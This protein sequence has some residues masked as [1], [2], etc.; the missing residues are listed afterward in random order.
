MRTLLIAE[1]QPLMREGIRR[2]LLCTFPSLEIGEAESVAGLFLAL[3]MKRWD[4]LIFNLLMAGYDAMEL[5]RQ[6]KR[7]HPEVPILAF[8]HSTEHQIAIRALQ[9]GASGCLA[10]NADAKELVQAVRTVTSGG[11]H[12]SPPAAEAL[13]AGIPEH[14]WMRH[15]R[16][17]NR[18]TEV[19]NLLLAGRSLKEIAGS[20]SVSVKTV[21]T[22]HSR[23]REKLKAHTDVELVRYALEHNL[24]DKAALPMW[25]PR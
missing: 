6:I 16:L 13:T 4:A 25:L 10:R 14:D 20:I 23:I 17:S 7:E 11:K 18:E 3:A 5:L 9:H 2:V 21:S 24:G 1:D 15:E 12:L 8:S 19:L 22:F